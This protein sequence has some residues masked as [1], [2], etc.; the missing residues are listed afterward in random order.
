[1]QFKDYYFELIKRGASLIRPLVGEEF[2]ASELDRYQHKIVRDLGLL[3]TFND[4]SNDDKG[5]EDA[6]SSQSTV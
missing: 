6:R 4:S 5:K 2:S 1:M 3:L